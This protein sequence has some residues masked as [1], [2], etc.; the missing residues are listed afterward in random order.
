MSII[1]WKPLSIA[2]ERS[3]GGAMEGRTFKGNIAIAGG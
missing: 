3:T 1:R 2:G